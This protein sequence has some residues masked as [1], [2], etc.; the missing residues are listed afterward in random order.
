[1]GKMVMNQDSK[2]PTGETNPQANLHAALAK[3]QGA[4]RNPERN[5]TVT[6]KTDKGSYT[7]DYAT[8]DNIIDTARKALSDN[9]LA[10]SQALERDQN[11]ASVMITRILHKDGGVL[12]NEMPI[13]LPAPDE[14][15]RPP[16]IQELGSIITY[17]RR[18]A[19]CSLLNIAAEEDDDGNEGRDRDAKPRQP[20]GARDAKDGT[21]DAFK[22]IRQAMLDAAD[23]MALAHV[24]LT[25]KDALME[26]KK[27]S[28]TGYAEL[29]KLKG[30]REAAFAKGE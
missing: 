27:V 30:D 1:M 15:G 25:E 28:E 23:A 24:V 9:G 21:R 12:V 3:A 26:I 20:A 14:R 22:R 4:M 6:V 7:F 18:Y 29:M 5:R 16:K 10:V 13:T 2:M 8:L 17:A 19:L 11:G